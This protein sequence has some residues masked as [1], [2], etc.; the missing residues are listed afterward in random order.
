MGNARLLVPRFRRLC[1]AWAVVLPAAAAL[2]LSGCATIQGAAAGRMSDSL[3]A[4][5]LDQ[6]DP[7]LVRDGLPAYLILMDALVKSDPEDARQLG[8][9]AQLYAAYG[10][11]FAEDA[12]RSAILTARARGYGQ[13]ALC[14]ADRHACRLDEREFDAYAAVLDRLDRGDADALY[15]YCVGSLAYIRGHSSDWIALA[16]LPKVERALQRLLSLPDIPN[17]ANVN[18]YLGVLSTLRP[19]AL[20]GRPAQ[21]RAY[22][23][24]A[25][26][27]SGG[28]DLAAKVE[29]ARSY[30]RLV[31]DRELHDRLL[32]E[33]VAAPLQHDGLTLFNALAQR[34]AR[35][36]LAS[37][38]DYF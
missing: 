7:D 37:A 22:F 28:R 4:A 13:R 14:A 34:Q 11:A 20:G 30:A 1:A 16:A 27:I 2:M 17:A 29:Y 38:D 36:L 33:V 25:I 9:A 6:E 8:A 19:E 15:S 31:Y 24:K 18:T 21:G 32:N 35:D 3:S 10:I 23:E 12:Q 26:E 5:I